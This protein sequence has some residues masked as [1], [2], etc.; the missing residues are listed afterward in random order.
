MYKSKGLG[1]TLDANKTSGNQ[2]ATEGEISQA[3]KVPKYIFVVV[4]S[5]I[6]VLIN[7]QFRE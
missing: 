1:R 6:T 3:W 5:G 7:N 2:P 4:E